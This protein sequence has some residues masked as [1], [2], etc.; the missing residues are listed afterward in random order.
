MSTLRKKE[1]RNR[2]NAIPT[3]GSRKFVR[4]P[5]P[6]YRVPHR[7]SAGPGFGQPILSQRILKPRSG[8]P[9][10]NLPPKHSERLSSGKNYEAPAAE[11]RTPRNSRRPAVPLP[12]QR[13]SYL[14]RQKHPVAA[15]RRIRIGEGEQD[16]QNDM[17]PDAPA[18]PMRPGP[19]SEQTR[20]RQSH[21]R[22][23]KS[24][25]KAT[26]FP[27][28]SA[29]RTPAERSVRQVR[30]SRAGDEPPTGD[31]DLA[32]PPVEDS[33]PSRPD[34]PTR[35]IAYFAGPMLPS[36]PTESDRSLSFS[37]VPY[38]GPTLNGS[39]LKKRSDAIKYKS[40][41]NQR[42]IRMASEVE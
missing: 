23:R 38:S 17:F 28:K 4:L 36:V 15:Q 11:H 41:R 10:P 3:S 25:E 31:P 33:E 18:A 34:R 27:T 39:T 2:R 16:P 22:S 6:A 19:T 12:E 1:K 13:T 7:A 20:P 14:P 40:H 26:L 29:R 24:P 5:A 21:A 37:R 30:M 9:Y 32:P 35:T 8:E 42:F